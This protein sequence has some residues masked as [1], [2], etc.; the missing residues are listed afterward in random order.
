MRPAFISQGVDFIRANQHGKQAGA[1]DAAFNWSEAN[2]GFEV[3]NWL[4][5]ENLLKK[6]KYVG[7]WMSNC[8][9]RG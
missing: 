2:L 4:T 1:G 8:M 7:G 3:T 9:T 5:A 6:L